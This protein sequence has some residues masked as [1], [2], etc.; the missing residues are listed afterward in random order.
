MAAKIEPQERIVAHTPFFTS[1]STL[2]HPGDHVFEMPK[3]YPAEYPVGHLKA[4]EPHPKA[5]QVV[6]DGNGYRD[7]F[8]DNLVP[9]EEAAFVPQKTMQRPGLEPIRPAGIPDGS[10]HRDGLWYA[11]LNEA[12]TPTEDPQLTLESM[13]KTDLQSALD[14]RGITYP[15]NAT[16]A[17]LIEAAE[18]NPVQPV[19]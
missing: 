13:S 16:K 14:A 17:A 9:V 7:G 4:F 8:T 2:A 18:A 11:P 19:I 10:I 6:A 5:G 12:L 3:T 15:P 1:Q